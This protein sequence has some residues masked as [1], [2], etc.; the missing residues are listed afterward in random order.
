MLYEF[1]SDIKIY[2]VADLHYGA[3]ECQVDRWKAFKKQLLTE[4]NSYITI[5]GDMVNNGTRTSVTNI[6]EETCRPSQ[7][8]KWLSEQL[9]DIKDRI[10]CVTG[11]NHEARSGKDA[12]DNPLYDVCAKLDIEDKFRENA[13]FLIIRMGEK[14]GNG[15]LN[16]TYT[17]CVT[18]STGGGIYTGAAVNR[19]ERFGM[20]I[21]GLD[22]LIT[23]HVHKGI[24]TKPQKIVFD[25]NNKRVSFKDFTV[26]SSTSWLEFGGYA[27]RKLL[28][29]ASNTI[30]TLLL[31]RDRKQAEVMW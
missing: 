19:N 16:P 25:T 20:V 29:P 8:K 18:H 14:D 4:P 22:I 9:E 15:R 30:Q 24:I 6:F 12:D 31:H 17:M 11:G 27:L 1:Q 5:A 2:P 10:L 13:A 23:G 3:A 28:I 26:V 7:Q 21:D